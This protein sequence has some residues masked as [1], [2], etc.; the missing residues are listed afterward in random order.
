MRK[1]RR[2]RQHLS[3][4][5]LRL[6]VCFNFFF[7]II[8]DFETGENIPIKTTSNPSTPVKLHPVLEQLRAA[9]PGG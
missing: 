5:I 9:L 6:F 3:I 8:I 1:H 2:I 7:L 4:S